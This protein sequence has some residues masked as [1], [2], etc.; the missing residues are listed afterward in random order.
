MNI[1]YSILA[2]MLFLFCFSSKKPDILKHIS[3][4]NT[5]QALLDVH[6]FKESDF[7]NDKNEIAF[8]K[9]V[10]VSNRA[11]MDKLLEEGVDIN[12][13]GNDSIS[14]LAWAFIK[15]QR[16]SFKYLLENGASVDLMLKG[17]NTILIFSEKQNDKYYY[18]M[19]TEN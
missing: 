5:P 3:E 1:R 17:G 4:I 16:N 7:Y 8:A 14:F 11:M 9:A 13:L 10:A 2:V 18:N 6:K 12:S 19:V 15:F